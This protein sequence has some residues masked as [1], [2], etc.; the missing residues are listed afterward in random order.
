MNLK[1]WFI[2]NKYADFYANGKKFNIDPVVARVIRNRDVYDDEIEEYLSMNISF[3][4]NPRDLKDLD[5]ATDI[6]LGKIDEGKKIRVIGDY[7]IDG[8]CSTYILQDGIKQV[9]GIVDYDIPDRVKDG[10]GINE[11]LIQKAFDEGIDTIITCDNGIAAREQIK[12]GKELGMTI[13]VTDHHDVPYEEIAGEKIEKIPEAD[14]VVDAK[15]LDCPYPFKELCGASI[16][17][18]FVTILLE[19][20]GIKDWQKYDY[21]EMAAIATIGDVVE[22]KKENRLIAKLGM[23]KIKSTINIGLKALIEVTGL[24]KE[25]ISSYHIGF[26]IG[27]CLNAGG[28]LYTAKLALKLFMC[29]DY[30]EALKIALELKNLNDR[31]K[32]MT[33][34][35][36][37]Q[38]VSIIEEH[39]YYN[40]K[41]IIAY[42]PDCHESIIGI[43][44]GRIREKYYRPTFILSKGEDAVKGSGRSIESFH[45]F[46]EMIKC[47]DIFEKFGGHAMA[48]GLS[49]KEENIEEFRRQ[50]NDN[51]QLGEADFV[52]KLQIDVPMPLDY[53]TEKLINDLSVIEPFGKGNTKPV[54]ARKDISVLNLRIMGKNRNVI[55]MQVR[56]DKYIF[57]AIYFGNVEK[58]MT[59][60]KDKFGQYEIEENL[61]KRRSDKVKL[62]MAYYPSV[63]EYM[64]RKSLQIIVSD[65]F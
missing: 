6:I 51:C 29:H 56:E 20:K 26:V 37:M 45:M 63:N 22:L 7:D 40:D 13:V 5:K 32:E 64:G 60:L 1:K 57:D 25:N 52:E 15:Q 2:T 9:G 59:Y 54:F 46:D 11:S 17:L 18:K 53:I 10:Y 8:V 28:R 34:K 21:L 42:L 61:M 49:I 12:Y 33:E 44:A 47:Q 3:L 14:A 62:S 4:N 65:Y 36:V 24:S 19:K 16:A 58:M 43:V 55:K 23:D 27:P 31:R 50:M 48:A 35:G 38:A 41:V 39:K 30:E